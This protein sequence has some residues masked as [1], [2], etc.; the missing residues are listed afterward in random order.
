[1]SLEKK[2]TEINIEGNLKGRFYSSEKLL[3]KQKMKTTM[4]LEANLNTVCDKYLNIFK[5]S[6]TF[7]GLL[8][9][10]E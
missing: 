9:L 8:D 5:Y 7:Y 4:N 10:F 3:V 2:K 6:N 1:M